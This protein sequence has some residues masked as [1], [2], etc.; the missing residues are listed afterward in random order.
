MRFISSLFLFAALL[1]SPAVAQAKLETMVFTGS[2]A[3]FLVNSTL[4][5]GANDAVLIDAQFA[6]ADAYRLVGWLIES[7]KNLTTIYITHAHPDHYFGLE[8]VKQAFPIRTGGAYH[9][10]RGQGA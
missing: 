3:G 1:S 8:V 9:P 4:V 7:R 2:P 5:S 10:G 6:M